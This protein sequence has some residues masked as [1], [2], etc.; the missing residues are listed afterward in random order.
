[1]K[2]PLRKEQMRV[3]IPKGTTIT[4]TFPGA[5]RTAGTS[6]TVDVFD[7][8]VGYVARDAWDGRH[9][10]GKPTSVVWVGSGGYW[11]YADFEDVEIVEGA[12]HLESIAKTFRFPL[13]TR[14]D[15]ATA[16]AKY[17]ADS[18]AFA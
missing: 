5:A 14:A 12:E 16:L 8:Y 11:H 18:S 1:M 9:M 4:G 10:V 3:R 17:E 13:V 7:I 15:V 6:F 2:H